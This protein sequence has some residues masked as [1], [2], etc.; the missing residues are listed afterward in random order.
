MTNKIGPEVQFTNTGIADSSNTKLHKPLIGLCHAVEE[1][2]QN[3]KLLISGQA[4][5]LSWQKEKCI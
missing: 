5:S 2:F 3:I 1:K 4:H